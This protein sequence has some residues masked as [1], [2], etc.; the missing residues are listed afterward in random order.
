MEAIKVDI[1]KP[2]RNDQGKQF[3]CDVCSKQFSYKSKLERHSQIHARTIFS[4]N[5]CMK[6]FKRE[7]HLKNHKCSADS[8][9][10][11]TMVDTNCI[12]AVSDLQFQSIPDNTSVS[13]IIFHIYFELSDFVPELV[14]DD[15]DDEDIDNAALAQ[16]TVSVLDVSTLT[17]HIPIALDNAIAPS[18]E[19]QIYLLMI[20]KFHN[21]KLLRVVVKTE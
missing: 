16:D 17:D 6:R 1:R 8:A 21:V 2:A 11:S 19:I 7:D 10:L 13:N 4:C 14:P 15:L 12:Q 3:T 20:K 5:N 18:A 9:H